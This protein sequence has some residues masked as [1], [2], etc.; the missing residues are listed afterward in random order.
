M[1]TCSSCVTSLDHHVLLLVSNPRWQ[2]THYPPNAR[3]HGASYYVALLTELPWHN[4]PPQVTLL[5]G[6]MIV[7]ETLPVLSS[8]VLGGGLQAVVIST[9][10]IVV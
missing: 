2:C 6:N 5:L 7:N 9:V 1:G 3:P 4:E 10:L 8:N